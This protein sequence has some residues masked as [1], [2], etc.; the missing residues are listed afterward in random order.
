MQGSV[1]G[2]ARIQGVGN[3]VGLTS[4]GASMN[5]A[6]QKATIMWL[7]ALLVLVIFHVGGAR[8]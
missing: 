3:V 2:A 5:P 6:M 4:S 7:G 1:A 8:F